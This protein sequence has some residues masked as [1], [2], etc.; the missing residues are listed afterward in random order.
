MR[1]LFTLF[2]GIVIVCGL[3]AQENKTLKRYIP[4][5][6]KVEKK[7]SFQGFRGS[8]VGGF[9]LQKTRNYELPEDTIPA[10][11]TRIML[12]VGEIFMDGMGYQMLITQNKDA[13]TAFDNSDPSADI[14]DA[15]YQMFEYKMPE[16]ADGALNSKNII[17]MDSRWIDIPAGTYIYLFPL[18]G[19]PDGRIYLAEG[20]VF[21][22]D[23]EAGV[24]YSYRIV[25]RES[26]GDE[27]LLDAIAYG[28][29]EIIDDLTVTPD[30]SKTLSCELSWMNPSMDV[31]GEPLKDLIS[32]TIMR[33]GE[34]IHTV[35]NPQMGAKETWTDTPE[36]NGFYTYSIYGTSSI[37]KGEV[38]TAPVVIVGENPCD[39]PISDFPYLE[40]FETG[41]L[42]LCWDAYDMDGNGYTWKVVQGGYDQSTYTASRPFSNNL[43]DDW[44]VTS[45]IAVPEEGNFILR[46]WEFNYFV[47]DYI[48]NSILIS[49]RSKNP[50]DGDF[51]EIWTPESVEEGWEERILFLKEYKGQE[52]Y[53]A[54]RYQGYNAHSW[55]V[56]N[57]EIEDFNLVD[58]Q[59]TDIISP[60]SGLDLKT[61]N[62]VIKI[63]NNGS[64]PINN[65]KVFFSIDGATIAEETIEDEIP[66]LEEYIYTFNEKADLSEERVY[67]LVAGINIEN[68]E[69]SGNDKRETEIRN[70]GYKA[71][72]GMV[73]RMSVCDIKFY[74]DGINDDYKNEGTKYVLT[75][76][77]EIE[78][79]RL[80]IEFESFS[81][82]PGRIIEGYEYE[83][84]SLFIYDGSL[85]EKEFMITSLGGDLSGNLPGPFISTA[86][87]GTLTFIFK[88]SGIG[89]KPGWE[90]NVK[91][92]S[93]APY[94]AG[95]RKILSPKKGSSKKVDVTVQLKNFGGNEIKSMQLAY[96]LDDNEPI[97]ETFSESIL[98]GATT[99]F[100]FTTKVDAS[101]Y[102]DD[103]KLEVYTMLDNDADP[104]NDKVTTIFSYRE[105]IKL[106]ANS[107]GATAEI[108]S[109]TTD[110]PDI[111]ISEHVVSDEGN[112]GFAAEYFDKSVYMMTA[113]SYLLAPKKLIK[114]SFGDWK[115]I[116]KIEVTGN[117]MP[118]DMTY[119][120]SSNTMYMSSMNAHNRT[121]SLYT[122]NLET[123][124][125]THIGDLG[126]YMSGIACSLD[127]KLYGVNSLGQLCEIDRS[128]AQL[129]VIH[130]LGL[131]NPNCVT[132]SLG[133]DHKTGRLF[134]TYLVGQPNDGLCEIDI[135]TGR[136]FRTGRISDRSWMGVYSPYDKQVDNI[137]NFNI[138]DIKVY[139]NPSNGI[140]N[141]SSVPAGSTINVI[142][143]SGRVLQ[144]YN[145]E[146]EVQLN[147]NLTEGV[148][149]IEI[150][151]NGSKLNK[152]IIIK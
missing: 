149:F 75:L 16:N 1:K 151:N 99:E 3:N 68:D 121:S 97:I 25:E 70:Y 132:Q 134:L 26:G 110:E 142:D 48:K 9:S 135:E 22:G 24:T 96:V 107:L 137:S 115:E 19:A 138:N 4:T 40:N 66:V 131:S 71:V 73:E 113:D 130:N 92:F 34:I 144:T 46:F 6:L 30:P 11:Y 62:V 109:F 76:L 67:T 54:F 145:R 148:Y 61:E 31:M 7:T 127:G 27:V 111:F 89:N 2:V 81:L 87:D 102:K 78:G 117:A 118:L 37:A 85:A 43:E 101:Q 15:V 86:P 64:S 125:Q 82:E 136:V 103:Y 143:L 49:T 119:D 128:T 98:P 69:V 44:L 150:I 84:D 146:G 23:F 147:L 51:V 139:P 47:T 114:L 112:M 45:K 41:E 10:G 5:P 116:S 13:V 126:I 129:T 120:Y 123:G 57:V 88:K 14:P 77:P 53:I 35:D 100:T 12:T 18:F 122:V 56:D 93:P 36:T 65:A 140:L 59:L 63:K 58:A 80:K 60:V 124:V 8:N 42:S 38:Y 91:C 106:Y 28:F 52:I 152:K 94:D 90:A 133:F 32:V 95:V 74:D 55:L 29:P 21:E 83:G 105:G 17:R 20:N 33:N 104:D 141:I 50:E 39:T 72:I 108:I 79:N